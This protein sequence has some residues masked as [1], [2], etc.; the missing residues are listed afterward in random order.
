[1][2]PMQNKSLMEQMNFLMTPLLIFLNMI[3]KLK[4]MSGNIITV[5][6]KKVMIPYHMILKMKIGVMIFLLW[7]VAKLYS[8]GNHS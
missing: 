5:T 3:W 6:L 4:S 1:M 8:I 7:M 2:T